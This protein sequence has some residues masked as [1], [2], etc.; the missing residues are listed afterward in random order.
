[1]QD[2]L[3]EIQDTLTDKQQSD[4]NKLAGIFSCELGYPTPEGFEFQ[5]A[6]APQPRTAYRMALVA[7]GLFRGCDTLN[8]GDHCLEDNIV[9][10]VVRDEVVFGAVQQSMAAP[11]S[12]PPVE[13]PAVNCLPPSPQ[14]VSIGR[15]VHYVLGAFDIERP[16][17]MSH[18]RLDG[19]HRS[20]LVAAVNQE[21][22]DEKG[23]VTLTIFFDEG[24]TAENQ[25][26]ARLRN[27]PYCAAKLPGTWHWPERA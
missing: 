25:L 11:M 5:N 7:F 18:I 26:M 21:T 9:D 15:V 24:D 13:S 23:C 4:L 12:L 10:G 20:A 6:F 17:F 27:V 2:E 22:G 8:E 19:V 1:M 3:Q 16:H 14:G